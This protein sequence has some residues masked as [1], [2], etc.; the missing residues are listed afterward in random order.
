MKVFIICFDGETIAYPTAF[1]DRELAEKRLR[2]MQDEM[3]ADADKHQRKS[4]SQWYSVEE[5]EPESSNASVLQGVLSF[6][7]PL[8]DFKDLILR[9]GAFEDEEPRK[10]KY[11]VTLEEIH[12]L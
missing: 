6:G 2:I 11:R 8:K 10:Y 5:M 9:D 3:D 7:S 1:L 12:E 4:Y